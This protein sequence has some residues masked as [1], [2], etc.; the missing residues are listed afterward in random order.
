[1]VSKL[2][3]GTVMAVVHTNSKNKDFS[4][5]RISGEDFKKFHKAVFSKKKKNRAD[6]NFLKQMP[7]IKG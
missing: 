3:K 5:I 2:Y 7:K 4:G 1:M 6:L